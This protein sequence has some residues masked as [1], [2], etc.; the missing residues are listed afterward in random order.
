MYFQVRLVRA[1][2]DCG[3]QHGDQRQDDRQAREREQ[4]QGRA[5]PDHV[6]GQGD[7]QD[8]PRC[9]PGVQAGPEQPTRDREEHNAR[10]KQDRPPMKHDPQVLQCE[11]PRQ[12]GDQVEPG[13]KHC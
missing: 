11:E 13:I 10:Q 5:Q 12:A 9:V 3:R 2:R 1:H 4:M 7:G 6:T 8:L